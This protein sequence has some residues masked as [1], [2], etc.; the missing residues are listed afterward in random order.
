MILIAPAVRDGVV[1]LANSDAAGACELASK[2]SP[3][4]R[5]IPS[6]PLEGSHAR[7]ALGRDMVFAVKAERHI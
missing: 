6:V 1:V 3:L 7:F 5:A 4:S 2:L